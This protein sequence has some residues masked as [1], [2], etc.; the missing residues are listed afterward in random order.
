M[1]FL[2]TNKN[3]KRLYSAP[4]DVT[5][6]FDTK[7][8][9][10]A[11]LSNPTAYV[12]Q[13]ISCKET[14]LVY[15][16]KS[17]KTLLEIGKKEEPVI[18]N[19][20]MIHSASDDK[21]YYYDNANKKFVEFEIG[22]DKTVIDGMITYNPAT[23]TYKRYDLDSDSF[24]NF[25]IPKE[26]GN[27]IYDV[28]TGKYKFFNGTEYEDLSLDADQTD[29]VKFD[30]STGGYYYISA[31]G[32][33]VE[34]E[35][36]NQTQV[37]TLKSDYEG[38]TK[39]VSSEEEFSFPIFFTTPNVGTAYVHVLVNNVEVKNEMVTQGNSK[40]NIGRLEKGNNSIKVYVVD[41]A[42]VYSNEVKFNVLCGALEIKS[43]FDPEVDFNLGNPVRIDFTASQ[44]NSNPLTLNV[45]ID[46]RITTKPISAGFN[47]YNIENLTI[48]VHKITL[49]LTDTEIESN[50]LNYQIVVIDSQNLYISSQFD[51]T[52]EYKES[53]K[54]SI[55]YRISYAASNEFN[56]KYYID[57]T[58]FR[59]LNGVLG[60]NYWNISTLTK[61]DRTLKIEVSTKDGSQTKELEFTIKILPS[62]FTR[63]EVPKVGILF[64]F[65]AQDLSNSDIGKENWT[66]KSGNNVVAELVGFNF[67]SNGW[68]NDALVCDGETYVK[69]NTTP[70]EDN[71]KY[72]FTLDCQFEVSDTGKEARVLDLTSPAASAQGFYIGVNTATLKSKS[73][74]LSTGFNEDTKT[75]ITFAIDRDNKFAKIYVNAV[76]CE[77]YKLTDD[78]VG[79]SKVFEDFSNSSY[80]YLNSR[81][82]TS[83][84]GNCKIYGVRAYDRCLTDDEI[85]KLHLAD[86]KDT[87]KQEAKYNFN[88]N[89]ELPTIYVY[90]DT[91]GISK[92][93]R[94]KVRINYMSTD[95]TKYG[96]SFDLNNCELHW[97]GTSS[98]QYPVKNY[99]I[100]LYD[101]F[102]KK[103]MYSP[104]PNGIKEN[105]FCLKADM[106][107]SAHYRN[108]GNAT[109]INDNLYSGTL[110]PAQQVDPNVRNTIDG[111]PINFYI[112]GEY[113]GVFNFNNDKSDK[114][115]FGLTKSFPQCISYEVS[116]NSNTTAGAFNKWTSAT[117]LTEKQYYYND[118]ELRYSS[119]SQDSDENNW[120]I[121]PL[122]TLVDW[123]SDA[124]ETEFR[125]NLD[126]HFNRRYL[127]DYYIFTMTTGLID[128]FGKN[129]MLTTWD[130][131]IF[132]PQFY[133]CDS[134]L[135]LNNSGY[136][137]YDPYIEVT[138]DVFN[139][140]DS[141]LWKKL[142]QYLWDEIVV[143]YRE[144][145][146]STLT[147]DK[148]MEYYYG[149]QI[150][151]IPERLY[152]TDM[153]TKYL[154]HTEYLFM[155]HGNDLEHLKS[156]LSKRISFL[157]NFFDYAFD[158]NNTI[159]IRANKHGNVYLDIETYGEQ[160]VKVKWKNGVEQK[161][162]VSSG[163]PTRFTGSLATNQDQEII[164]YNVNNLKS[165]GD[166]SNLN[167]SQLFLGNAT[168]LTELICHSDK[169]L[170]V[171]VSNNTYLQKIDLK[172]C[173]L[174]GKET[175]AV[176]DVSGLNNLKYLNIYGTNITSVKTNIA[177]G[178]LVEIYYPKT[179]KSI[180][181]R[182][183]SNLTTLAIPNGNA[184]DDLT[185]VNLDNLVNINATYDEN[186]NL[187]G[188]T[189]DIESI[190]N[191]LQTINIQNCLDVTT[192]LSIQD[193]RKLV[194]LVLVGMDNLQSI[195]LGGNSTTSEGFGLLSN[196]SIS[197]CSKFNTIRI[198]SSNELTHFI[199][200]TTIDLGNCYG[201]ANFFDEI[202]IEGT[203]KILLPNSI[204]VIQSHGP[205]KSSVNKMWLKDNTTATEGFD[206]Q[207]MNLTNNTLDFYSLTNL[208]S[209]NNM[210]YITTSLD[211]HIN[212]QRTSKGYM[213]LYG[214]LDFS[215]WDISSDEKTALLMRAIKGLKT[216]SHDYTLILPE[217]LDLD[218]LAKLE[219]ES[220][221]ETT[222]WSEVF[223][224]IN[225]STLTDA[226]G[227]FMNK[228]FVD[229]NVDL[230]LNAPN[231]VNCTNM[232]KGSNIP[233]ITSI[234]LTTDCILDSMFEECRG[235][236][237]DCLIPITTASCKRMFCNCSNIVTTSNNYERY[238]GHYFET[239]GMYY[240]VGAT[241]YT[242][243]KE[244]TVTKFPSTGR[245]FV[246]S[247]LFEYPTIF[248]ISETTI[249]T[250]KIQGLS[251]TENIST[252][253][254]Y[255]GSSTIYNCKI[256]KGGVILPNS[257]GILA[258][259]TTKK[260]YNEY[261]N[262]V[263]VTC[264]PSLLIIPYIVNCD[265]VYNI[266]NLKYF[267]D[268]VSRDGYT[269]NLQENI[270]KLCGLTSIEEILN[271]NKIN[272]LTSL[273][274]NNYKKLTNAQ[275]AFNSNTTITTVNMPDTYN[276]ENGNSM[277]KGCTNLTTFTIPSLQKLK[278]GSY[279]FYDCRKLSFD[280][281]PVTEG[282]PELTNAKMMFQTCTNLT[283]VDL[284]N[285]NKLVNASDMFN[286]CS[287][288]TEVKNLNNCTALENFSNGLFGTSITSIDLSGL[289]AL[290]NMQSA[291]ATC[292]KL[293][294]VTGLNNLANCTNISSAFKGCTALKSFNGGQ[295]VLLPKVTNAN[296]AFN[297][298]TALRQVDLNLPS[299]TDLSSNAN[300]IF[301]GCTLTKI[302][303]TA[304][305]CTSASNVFSGMSS[306]QELDFNPGDNCTTYNN[307]LKG[308]TKLMNLKI[309]VEGYDS[310]GQSK[311]L[312]TAT[313][314]EKCLLYD[315]TELTDL[316][317]Y[318]EIKQR[319]NFS[320]NKKLSAASWT[321]IIDALHDYSG[322]SGGTT[323]TIVM[324]EEKYRSLTPEGF[325]QFGDKGWTVTR[326]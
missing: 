243:P 262:Y 75:R 95:E 65:S 135:S 13:V 303:I 314:S 44:L 300:G 250:P 162:R 138:P 322:E 261:N 181:V 216:N 254:V 55:D 72:G 5:S 92:Y 12:G 58:L 27:M 26:T 247:N 225:D 20:M 132:Y 103:Y 115:V 221:P 157:D 88:F 186:G 282:F 14:D 96:S 233:R 237:A 38:S 249:V 78:G 222:P 299:I 302:T 301:T 244:M 124:D 120:D 158:E 114:K 79:V 125:T 317:F 178:N 50:R 118:F 80:I 16:I 70:L 19:G 136:R 259:P 219:L 319:M 326:P 127:I 194:S 77:C 141:K 248:V 278:D 117:G 129:M 150:S 61:G 202:G 180:D 164:I 113:I 174:L 3:Y 32:E 240:G 296:D 90:G 231:L 260:G 137:R 292:T 182:N 307:T 208:P 276:L 304:I 2:S 63:L 245:N 211:P 264:E 190:F 293:T 175:G 143:R 258:N 191:N 206:Q 167:P 281:I 291:F 209:W 311:E 215:R 316:Y 102:G 112:N 234:D 153:N 134:C 246:G 275:S 105:L 148:L 4:L 257:P 251:S 325:K 34:L 272:K 123:V 101:E 99:R 161:L 24:V 176:M 220:L 68:M 321:R 227:L 62:D 297:G 142:T 33:R 128:N 223:A 54:V 255:L 56:V 312:S 109:Y 287:A 274:F 305:N 130:S 41:R 212:T 177:G 160:Y 84:F 18:Q 97:Q 82:G 320:K 51:A 52:V 64:D 49:Y 60:I 30:S 45:L 229:D 28:D 230:V 89:N 15:L 133:D 86:I 200:N 289:S 294:T 57:G 149:H 256:G 205:N 197:E 204:K 228:N 71:I 25:E 126:Q 151:K 139:T 131:Q 323:H 21:Y 290:K 83:E 308:C 185:L 147:Y 39:T 159:T 8:E 154:N 263:T 273:N 269:N 253:N 140:S 66:D 214:T 168:R 98:L 122:K 144:L 93:D 226:T 284:K 213:R 277:F 286:G 188:I 184:L 242:Y 35:I 37:A 1:S 106:M 280:T 265:F 295:E 193:T 187:T 235:L 218:A 17:D 169:L 285:T 69:I 283:T 224:K 46:G 146:Q 183:Q 108:T 288:L 7:S 40:I 116:A 267:K 179:I 36:G 81:K 43:T 94:V 266:K 155:L 121:T 201:L 6:V 310:E 217:G 238:Y 203:E 232:F 76:L 74:V 23:K 270:N 166:I 239:L 11:Y 279:M 163:K 104:F 73:N 268:G 172:G 236:Q 195:V 85:V 241:S 318:G 207:G 87:K 42:G 29:T 156:W 198:K 192:T 31:N 59:T 152:N 165:I 189:S 298:C 315:C 170:N 47:T 67:S 313:S 306:L 48:G 100:R 324:S 199:G 110:N 171:D 9:L 173:S 107:D 145:R 111:F 10:D 22:I 271:S 309:N 53:D 252:E 91:T 196:I 119:R 210:N